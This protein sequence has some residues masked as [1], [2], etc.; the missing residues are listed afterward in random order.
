MTN[1]GGGGPCVKI[2]S[3]YSVFITAVAALVLCRIALDRIHETDSLDM[4][5]EDDGE[6]THTQGQE[7]FQRTTTHLQKNTTT[8]R[9]DESLLGPSHFLSGSAHLHQSHPGLSSAVARRLLRGPPRAND[10]H[11]GVYSAGHGYYADKL[12]K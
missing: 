5:G 10:Y 12:L 1:G 7:K 9:K 4:E 2:L 3:W 8:T 11:K 6:E